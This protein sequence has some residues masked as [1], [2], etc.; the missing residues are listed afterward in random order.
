MFDKIMNRQSILRINGN[1][2]RWYYYWDVSIIH[3]K[4]IVVEL[5]FVIIIGLF[6]S[7]FIFLL[8]LVKIYMARVLFF[9]GKITIVTRWLITFNCD[10]INNFFCK[11]VIGQLNNNK[12]WAGHIYMGP[13]P[14][15]NNDQRIW[16]LA[17][18]FI[19][20]RQQ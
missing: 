6:H 20:S 11:R 7:S 12:C 13:G 18:F 16:N 9:F 8:L 3:C 1:V 4:L 5:I 19:I 14:G 17:H 15:A 2:F 10:N